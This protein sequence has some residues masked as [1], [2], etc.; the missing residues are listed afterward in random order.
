MHT[1]LQDLRHAS[2]LLIRNP[3][4][5][6]LAVLTLAL[7]IGGSTAVF[8]VVEARLFRPLP[9]EDSHELVWVMQ[10]DVERGWDRLP[11]S[12]PNFI[13]WREQAESFEYLAASRGD[14][15]TVRVGDAAVRTQFLLVTP[16]VFPMLGVEAAEGRAFG[17]DD[18]LTPAMISMRFRRAYFGTEQP[19]VGRTLATEDGVFEVVGGLPE[20][21]RFPPGPSELAPDVWAP[22][23]L[24][25]SRLTD[26]GANRLIAYG[27]L[28]DGVT[29]EQAG[30]ELE[31]IAARLAEAYPDANQ[32]SGANLGPLG[33]LWYDSLRQES[34]V[35][36]GAVGFVLLIGCANIAN[37]LL[38]RLTVRQG[39]MSV[40]LALG[41]SRGRL[42]RQL[43]TESLLLA[44][45][46]GAVGLPLAYWGTSALEAMSPPMTALVG[47]IEVDGRVL[48]FSCA[49]TLL[50]G[51]VFGLIP[52]L[53]APL[54]AISGR[55]RGAGRSL[56]G[57]RTRLRSALIVGEI[58][59][60]LISLTAAG[61][62]LR[63]MA[64]AAWDSPGFNPENL[65]TFRTSAPPAEPG[66]S[67]NLPVLAQA[68]R[69][70]SALPGVSSTALAN[71]VP[72]GSGGDSK[73]IRVEGRST[74]EGESAP[75]V[76]YRHVSPGYFRTMEN[77]LL[78]GRGFN[79]GDDASA[80]GVAV[81]NQV[82]ADQFLAGEDPL[83]RRVSVGGHSFE[84]SADVESRTFEIVGVVAAEK[85]WRLDMKPEPEIY[86]PFAQDPTRT[87]D[88]I[89]RTETDVP[90]LADAV[91][92]HFA[93]ADAGRPVFGFQAMEDRIDRSLATPRFGTVLLG[94][95]AALGLLLAA[96][97]VYGV[98]AQ[99][100]AERTREIGLRVALGADRGQVLRMV[101]RRG[102]ILVA[103]G[104]ATGLA[105]ALAV[106][107]GLQHLYRFR[108]VSPRDPATFAVAAVTLLLAAL[109]ACYLPARRA[110]GI[111]PMEALRQE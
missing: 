40:R 73:W 10:T 17:P 69:H 46:G 37:L 78:L 74:E 35:L 97:G 66:Q 108:G 72:L 59:L 79:D 15:K 60:A 86:V 99:A 85:Y 4:F 70:V 65:L 75:P 19:V 34:P 91:R 53:D 27:R 61:L 80:P 18:G 14:D 54:Q 48:A 20:G 57:A 81:V 107:Q 94:L 56:I 63:G 42:V 32:T 84:R 39:E 103:V 88:F 28:R 102:F 98:M 1:L 44:A 111:E 21:L 105:G 33:E 109:L 12:G 9:F 110:S 5:T 89:V 49:A 26:R 101:F 68:L 29:Q 52:A 43:M 67:R 23:D 104:L 47:E 41:A 7:G 87:V 82:F 30:A 13:D 76:D 50:S 45:L 22:L 36:L 38:A 106:S 95:F 51:L 90:G 8:S 6:L 11:L 58:T 16:D 96:V 24:A 3:R 31:S 93:E 77:V 55:M 2:R 71:R 62:M 83:G 64:K 25:S 92:A 100:V